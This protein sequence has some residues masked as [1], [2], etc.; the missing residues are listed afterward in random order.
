MELS[1]GA[2]LG[3]YR[4]V[5]RA[6]VGGMAEVWRA[7]QISLDRDVAI[8]I[9][10]R[11]FASQQNFVERFRRE[12]LAISRLDHPHILPIYDFGEQDGFPYMVTP[13]IGGGTLAQ[14]LGSPWPH[15]EV[16]DLLEALASALDFAH[17]R[18]VVHRD[19]KP[20]NVLLTEQGRV[21]LGDFGV[22]RM[23]EEA[24]GLTQAEA[25]VGTPQYMAPEA[26]SGGPAG[27]ASDLYSLGVIVYELL[28]GRVPFQADTPLAVALAHLSQAPPPA[29]TLNPALSRAVEAALSRALA[30][31]ASDRFPSGADMVRSVTDALAG[32]P[33]AATMV[34]PRVGDDSAGTR[35]REDPD[36]REAE[37][38]HFPVAASPPASAVAP[39]PTSRQRR[40]PV[41]PG[42]P[43]RPSRPRPSVGGLLALAAL[44]IVLFAALV[45]GSRLLSQGPQSDTAARPT[46]AAAP[47]STPQAAAN[48]PTAAPAAAPTA[49]P[50]PTASTPPPPTATPAP[51]PTV[52]PPTPAPAPP[53][54]A[55][56]AP[57]AP[58]EPAPAAVPSVLEP[59]LQTDRARVSSLGFRPGEHAIT[60]DGQGGNLI[61]IKGTCANSADG[62]CQQVFFFIGTR[63]L[64]TDTLNI[65]KAIGNIAPAGPARI[66]V[67]YPN[68]RASDP[69]CCP[70]QPPVTITYT[71]NG[72]RLR[73]NPWPPPGHQ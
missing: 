6:G 15:A 54:A 28:T 43:L 66:Q 55:A 31:Q 24:S 44:A 47:T 34:L 65:S 30:K 14:R 22:A 38:N 72:E 23:V 42:P 64:G 39:E 9:I 53:K 8:K 63:Y 62:S 50:V 26:A 71:W 32:D 73:P 48:K 13:F 68:Y 21:V 40:A 1:P 36:R 11:Q 27:P 52:V 18:G 4:L 67:T 60:A 37:S 58:A 29:R 5:E 59:V 17:A 69:L 20:S 35:G 3:S 12:A 16:L 61:A 45:L 49:P 56:P 51:E 25:M 33:A 19:V 2:T 7:V 10:L 70:S 41:S 46:L 57:P